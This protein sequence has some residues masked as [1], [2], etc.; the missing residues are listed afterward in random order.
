MNKSGKDSPQRTRQRFQ[1]RLASF[2]ML[3]SVGL[4]LGGG[5]VSAQVGMSLRYAVLF[6]LIALAGF[7]FAMIVLLQVW[8]ARQNQGE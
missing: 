8:R 3:V 6:D 7:A 1:T 2:V 5:W 4:S